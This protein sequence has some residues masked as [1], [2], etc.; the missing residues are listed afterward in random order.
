MEYIAFDAHKHYTLAS[1][2][3]ADGRLL[4][5][6]RRTVSGDDHEGLPPPGTDSGQ[7]DPEEA[8]RLAQPGPRERSLVHGELVAQGEVLEGE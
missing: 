5:E 7:P 2:A 3:Q 8:I 6:H 4:R 1:V